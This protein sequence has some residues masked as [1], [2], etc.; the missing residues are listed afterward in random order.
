MIQG[1]VILNTMP[2]KHRKNIEDIC[3]GWIE[4]LQR[5]ENS[6][7]GRDSIH[8]YNERACIGALSA[9]IWIKGGI[10]L[11]EY[12]STKLIGSKKD[13]LPKYGRVDLYFQ[14]DSK[15]NKCSSTLVAI[16]EAKLRWLCTSQRAKKQVIVDRIKSTLNNAAKDSENS[17]NGGNEHITLAV[18]FFPTYRKGDADEDVLV[19]IEETLESLESKWS[20]GR[21]IAKFTTSVDLKSSNDNICNEIYMVVEYKNMKK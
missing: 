21:A 9:G 8:W 18:S 20:E 19:F 1:K 6:Y 4:A 3:N 17:F 13:S 12:Q 15:R 16:C 11:E 10:T 2:S 5:Y 7:P 14:I